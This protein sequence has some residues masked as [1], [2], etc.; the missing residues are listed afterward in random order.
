MKK[1]WHSPKVLFC[2]VWTVS[3]HDHT[4]SVKTWRANQPDSA[5]LCQMYLIIEIQKCLKRKNTWSLFLKSSRL[6]SADHFESSDLN[7]M[8]WNPSKSWS[9]DGFPEQFQKRISVEKSSASD[10][11]SFWDR[12]VSKLKK[13]LIDA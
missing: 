6:T 4:S 1:L 3:V 2:I 10:L 11:K 8:C 9:A 12:L 5:S 7:L 13:I